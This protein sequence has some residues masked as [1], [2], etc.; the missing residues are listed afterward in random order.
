MTSYSNSI[1]PAN[2]KE[3]HRGSRGLDYTTNRDEE[4]TTYVTDRPEPLN[5]HPYAETRVLHEDGSPVSFTEEARDARAL[6]IPSLAEEYRDRHLQ[7]NTE[8]YVEFPAS[9]PPRS[10]GLP[11][12]DINRDRIILLPEHQKQQADIG[13]VAHRPDNEMLFIQN[14]DGSRKFDMMIDVSNE[15]NRSTIEFQS[16][17]AGWN[18]EQSQ[19]L[20][21]AVF[22]I[23]E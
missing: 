15:S 14:Q 5:A 7:Q 11:P 12:L 16:R 9:S 6:T 13:I 10:S 17:Q 2:Q 3:P 18:E 21:D 1:K 4:G 23:K 19:K 22:P 8:S 20:A